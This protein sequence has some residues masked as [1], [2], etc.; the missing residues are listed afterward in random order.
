MSQAA[1]CRQH[2]LN[3][4][5]FSYHKRKQPTELAVVKPSGFIRL[6]LPQVVA[7]DEALMLHLA[8]GMRLSGIGS[9]N[10]ALV[11]QLA[12]VLS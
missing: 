5:S 8:N 4:N 10:I 1:Y 11:K 7:V 6:P 12:Q 3:Q 9:G 2:G